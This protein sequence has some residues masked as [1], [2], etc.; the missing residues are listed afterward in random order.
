MLEFNCLDAMLANL[1]NS[2]DY[3]SYLSARLGLPDPGALFYLVKLRVN[4]NPQ[5]GFD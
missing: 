4:E 2:P 1:A 3:A 5:L